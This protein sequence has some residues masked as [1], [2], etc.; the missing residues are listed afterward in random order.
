MGGQAVCLILITFVQCGQELLMFLLIIVCLSISGFQYSGFVIN[1]LDICPE[2]AGI[3]NGIGQTLS[4]AAGFLSAKLMG[5]MTEGVNF[6]LF[7]KF[8][9]ILLIKGFNNKLEQFFLF[10]CCCISNRNNNIF[11][12]CKR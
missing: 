11:N 1:Y 12:I 10:K 3:V 9:N 6:F 8:I 2:Y 4:C 7:I 5:F